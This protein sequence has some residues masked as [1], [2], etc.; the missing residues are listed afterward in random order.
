M[1]TGPKVLDNATFFARLGQR[2]IHYLSAYTAAGRLYEVDSRL[3]PSGTAGL[4]VT[5]IEAFAQYQDSQAW[6]WEHQALVRARFVAG[7]AALGARFDAVRRR[8][9][10][11]DRD[12]ETLRAE[13]R[14]MRHRQREA[15]AS[16]FGNTFALKHDPGG[17][18]DIEFLVQYGALRWGSKM[19]STHVSL[20]QNAYR[21]FRAR[22][23]ELDLQE[24]PAV[25]EAQ[26][27]AELSAQ[28]REVWDRWME[29]KDE[30]C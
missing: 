13:V 1:T 30:S 6:T 5:S 14:D 19:P 25:V 7:D 24:L 4:L 3:R 8:I 26:E 27:F 17:I 28:V 22:V 23:H 2:I 18:A 16:T 12:P 21:A 29:H 11:R 10:T 15:F 20:L 9:L